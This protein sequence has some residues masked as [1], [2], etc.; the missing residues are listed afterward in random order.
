VTDLLVKV[1]LIQHFKTTFLYL[2]SLSLTVVLIRNPF[3]RHCNKPKLFL[4]FCLK[5][6][7]KAEKGTSMEIYKIT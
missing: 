4:I 2:C 5:F 6:L 7:S 1:Y 3:Q